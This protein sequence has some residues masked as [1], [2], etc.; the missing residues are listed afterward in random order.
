MLRNRWSLA[1][2]VIFWENEL[3]DELLKQWALS[4]GLS[5]LL[6]A[7][8]LPSMPPDHPTPAVPKEAPLQ[9]LPSVNQSRHV[10][11]IPPQAPTQPGMT[12]INMNQE[13]AASV[14]PHVQKAPVEVPFETAL[15]A[16]F[17]IPSPCD[18]WTKEY[19]DSR[20]FDA[21][22]EIIYDS[23]WEWESFIPENSEMAMTSIVDISVPLK[24]PVPYTYRGA[25][26]TTRWPYWKAAMEDQLRKLE[27][28]KTWKITKLP[29]GK[30]AIPC[31]WVFTL[32]TEAKAKAR[33]S[34]SDIGGDGEISNWLETARLV[35]CGDL[36]REGEDYGE[37]FAP[38]IK[39]VSLRMLLTLAA[40]FDVD[41]YY[42]DVVAAFLNGELEEE[43]YMK[44][45]PGF[46]T[47]YSTGNDIT[48]VSYAD[49]STPVL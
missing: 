28:A 4:N 12:F 48:E 39:L 35:A 30:K 3:G 36:Q 47:R 18:K 25:T 6:V 26:R 43:V 21:N 10:L 1:R 32:K 20:I 34:G 11:S 13:A 42:W 5:I 7:N 46:E 49:N 24:P 31:K 22:A 16:Q 33:A 27:D 45:P 19:V 40:I 9:P 44:L 23:L 8:E 15:P 38:I 17:D 2:D 29:D 37:T 41:L 14:L